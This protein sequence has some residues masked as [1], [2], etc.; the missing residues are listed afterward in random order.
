MQ[1]ESGV[2]SEIHFPKPAPQRLNPR[3]CK[4]WPFDTSGSRALPIQRNSLWRAF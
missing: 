4:A 2:A 1:R 3:F